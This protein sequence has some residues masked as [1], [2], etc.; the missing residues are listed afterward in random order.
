[1]DFNGKRADVVD[2]GG[3]FDYADH[4]WFQDIPERPPV[5]RHEVFIEDYDVLT[6][7]D[8]QPEPQPAPFVPQPGVIEQNESFE[9]ALSAAP[10]VLYG[11]YKQYGQA[12]FCCVVFRVQPFC[13]YV[14]AAARRACVVFGV[15][16]AHRGAQRAR[17]PGQHACPDTH[18]GSENV[19]RNPQAALRH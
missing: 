18:T 16:R 19:R 12:S 15:W 5:S 7:L 11:R 9:Y 14:F 10:N 1:M 2:F 13:S 3:E 17:I 6:H 4:Q 8:R